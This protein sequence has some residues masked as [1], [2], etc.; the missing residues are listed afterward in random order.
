MSAFLNGKDSRF[1]TT[2][3]VSVTNPSSKFGPHGPNKVPLKAARRVSKCNAKYAKHGKIHNDNLIPFW[4]L[5]LESNGAMHSYLGHLISFA[6]DHADKDKLVTSRRYYRSTPSSQ[7]ILDSPY[8]MYCANDRFATAG[9]STMQCPNF[10]QNIKSPDMEW[11]LTII[12]HS[13]IFFSRKCH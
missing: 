4:P 3:I 13:K 1:D 12:G 8:F 9:K 5:A 11:I 7:V 2:T 10:A 6:A